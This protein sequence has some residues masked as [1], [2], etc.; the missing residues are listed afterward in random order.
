LWAL[1]LALHIYEVPG[2]IAGL[3][4]T[5]PHRCVTLTVVSPDGGITGYR[6]SWLLIQDHFTF[7]LIYLIDNI[8]LIISVDITHTSLSTAGN[9]RHHRTAPLNFPL[10]ISN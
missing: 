4:I 5:C 7:T 2:Y 8:S 1:L 10:K 9:K 6:D 3:E